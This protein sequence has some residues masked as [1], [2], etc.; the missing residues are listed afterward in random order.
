MKHI[1]LLLC[2]MLV[3]L[4]SG[5]KNDNIVEGVPKSEPIAFKTIIHDSFEMSNDTNFVTTVLRSEQEEEA[6]IASHLPFLNYAPGYKSKLSTVDY[7]Q[8]MVVCILLGKQGSASVSIT[9]DSIL[10]DGD[11]WKVCSHI[12][13][14][15]VMIDMT[16][17]PVHLVTVPRSIL[18]IVFNTIPII[19]E[20][21]GN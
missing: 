15:C 14:P 21:N 4:A 3:D 10:Q 16:G 13:Y 18:P 9:I 8:S 7:Q 17:N 11:S 1:L 12:F 2:V 19:R 6:F 20:C 5:C